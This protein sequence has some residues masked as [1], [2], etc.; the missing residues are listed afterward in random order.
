MSSPEGEP[1]PWTIPDLPDAGRMEYDPRIE[2]DPEPEWVRRITYDDEDGIELTAGLPR[3][4]SGKE[5]DA[6][7]WIL[8]MKAYFS[9]NRETYN[10]KAQTLVTLNKMRTRRGA[11]FSEGWYLKLDNNDIPPDQKTFAKLDEDF[12]QTFIPKGLEDRAHQE[13]YSLSME[14][15]KGDFNQYASTFRLAQVYSGIYL[16]SILVDTLQWGVSNQLAMMMTSTALPLGQKK[17]GW[18]WEQ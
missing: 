17:T 8:S 5:E 3:N 11:T 9:I 16:D 10:D 14:Q 6:T 4:F 18:R 15:F 1:D 12:H 2:N 7:R 13:V